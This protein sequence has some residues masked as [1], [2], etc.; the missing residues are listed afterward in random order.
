MRERDLVFELTG[1]LLRNTAGFSV[2]PANVE[3]TFQRQ[4]TTSTS[5][6]RFFSINTALRPALRRC[7]YTG[8]GSVHASCVS[9]NTLPMAPRTPSRTR[10]VH[11]TGDEEA[12]LLRRTSSAPTTAVWMSVSMIVAGALVLAVGAAPSVLKTGIALVNGATYHPESAAAEAAV[13]DA[14][15]MRPD[16]G[17]GIKM[18]GDRDPVGIEDMDSLDETIDAGTMETID[19]VP[20]ESAEER[21]EKQT[22]EEAEL[23][24]EIEK[25]RKIREGRKHAERR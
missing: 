25:L 4:L 13:L 12:P 16:G 23:R 21:L 9:V 18:T 15:V 11:H 17:P 8:L 7:L 14:E 1:C 20:A 6:P 10:T 3:T 24:K 22:E 19:V 2:S 5:T